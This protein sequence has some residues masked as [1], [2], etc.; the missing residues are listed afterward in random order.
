NKRF[1]TRELS[2]YVENKTLII[3]SVRRLDW[4]KG[5]EHGLMAIKELLKTKP[6][7]RWHIV[8]DGPF[9]QALEWAIRDEGLEE[10]VILEGARDQDF[11]ANL[12]RSSTV[13]F[14]PAVHEGISNAVL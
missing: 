7:L 13:Y 5:Y 1:L 2:A 9:R 14:H 6:N 10:V 8:G 4:R 12:L 3:S 11:I